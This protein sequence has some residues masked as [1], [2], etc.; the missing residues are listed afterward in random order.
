MLDQNDG[1][2]ELVV[3]VENETAHVLLFLEVHAGHRLIEQQQLR[4][5]RKSARELHALLQSVGQPADG[6]LAYM[7]YLE[8]VDDR[9]DLGT[10]LELLAPRGSPVERLLQEVRFHLEVASGHDVVEHRHAAK[11]GDVLEGAGDSLPR[12]FVGIDDVAPLALERDAASLRVVDAVDDVEHRGLARAV[13]AD[14]GAD[15]VRADI[16]GNALEGN[17]SAEGEG[18]VVD[19]EDG[20][21]DFPTRGHTSGRNRP[22]LT[23]LPSP[24]RRHCRSSPP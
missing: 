5:R 12:G 13:R 19:L 3:D 4:L 14:D 9:L 1:G 8:E 15:F 10:V 17:H 11:K 23:P 21:A 2:A 6:G 16:E 22:G 7:L 24:R 18:D 20:C